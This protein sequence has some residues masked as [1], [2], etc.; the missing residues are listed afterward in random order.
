MFYPH[1][2]LFYFLRFYLFLEGREGERE[3]SVCGCL[4]S[5]PTGSLACKPGMCPDWESNWRPFGSQACAQSIEL[6]H[7]GLFSYSFIAGI[8]IA[9]SLFTFSRILNLVVSAKEP[10]YNTGLG[11]AY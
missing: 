7:P 10:V 2:C 9:I 6:H 1:A 5:V 11:I 3:T 4:S 8:Y